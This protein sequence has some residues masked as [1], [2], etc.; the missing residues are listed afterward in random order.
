[1]RAHQPPACPACLLVSDDTARI[2]IF[3]ALAVF[4]CY[5]VAGMN[6]SAH[7]SRSLCFQAA[8]TLR[9]HQPPA[10]LACLH[11]SDDT[12]RTLYFPPSLFSLVIMWLMCFH[13]PFTRAENE[14]TRSVLLT[15]P[16]VL[17]TPSRIPCPLSWSLHN[18]TIVRFL[19][20]RKHSK[21]P[22]SRR[23]QRLLTSLGLPSR[24]CCTDW[25][26]TT[27]A[28]RLRRFNSGSVLP[29]PSVFR[30]SLSGPSPATSQ[31]LVGGEESLRGSH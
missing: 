15:S 28:G 8:F 21:K 25:S 22:L 5:H 23:T 17:Y 2:F 14:S 30:G 1:M 10:C 18:P 6:P 16:K 29:N 4:A 3:S 7:H 11:V 27:D 13:R 9:A 31:V 24:R 12:A 20:C 19:E 26:S